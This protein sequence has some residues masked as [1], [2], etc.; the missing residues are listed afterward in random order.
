VLTAV[1]KIILEGKL[2]RRG[3]VCLTFL[4]HTPSLREAEAGTEA[5]A[6][7]EHC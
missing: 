7:E 1:V 6:M 4:R 5:Q 3:I 2:G